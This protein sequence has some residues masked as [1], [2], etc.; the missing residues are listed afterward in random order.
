MSQREAVVCREELTRV[1]NGL[2]PGHRQCYPQPGHPPARYIVGWG[3]AGCTSKV[4]YNHIISNPGLLGCRVLLLRGCP[5]EW[6]RSVTLQTRLR[7][8]IS[9][10]GLLSK[11]TTNRWLTQQKGITSQFWRLE[12]HNQGVSRMGS[13]WGLGGKDLLQ[14]LLLGILR[15]SSPGVQVCLP[16]S[17]LR[18]FTSPS[19]LGPSLTTSC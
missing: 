13:F 8:C 10:L 16:V 2:S 7:V 15:W 9:W 12:V 18:K 1:P 11:S 14:A 3:L 4:C 5:V 6:C 17:P 19:G